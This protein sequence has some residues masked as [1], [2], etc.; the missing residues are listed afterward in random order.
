MTNEERVM[1]IQRGENRAE[2]L[3]RL[4]YDNMGLWHKALSPYYAFGDKEELEQQAF[5]ILVE[6]VQRYQPEK[7]AFSTWAVFIIRQ[8]IPMYLASCGNGFSIPANYP[9]LQAKYYR[10][11]RD[12]IT[13]EN[14]LAKQLEIPVEQVRLLKRRVISYNVPVLEEDGELC[15]TIPS[16]ENVEENVLDRVGSEQ[17]HGLVWKEVERIFNGKKLEIIKACFI[18]G[19]TLAEISEKYG[20]T[21]QAVSLIL[22][23]AIKRMQNSEKLQQLAQDYDFISIFFWHGIGIRTWKHTGVSCVEKCV[24]ERLKIEKKRKQVIEDIFKQEEKEREIEKR[25]QELMAMYK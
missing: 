22:N 15:D 2:N 4:Y 24:F 19:M 9:I 8:K 13:D 25:F 21:P 6:A 14:E 10:L 7:G 3:E 23:K 12:G 17:L 5:V 1:F 18:D 20:C 11:V 16:E